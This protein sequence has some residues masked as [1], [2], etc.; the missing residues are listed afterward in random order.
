[1]NELQTFTHKQFGNVRALNIKGEPWFVAVDVCKALGVG[2]PTQALTRLDDDE[3]ANTLISNEGIRGNPNMAIVNEPGLY[4]LVLS[5]RK[6]QAKAFKR[7]LTHDVI[8]S[9]RKYGAYMTPETLEAAILN[10]D[11]MIKLC[12]Q[13]KEEQK[14]RKALELANQTLTTENRVLRPKADY[15]D[16]VISR[17]KVSGIRETAKA[18]K[19]KQNDFVKLLIDNHYLYRDGSGRLQPYSR[20]VPSLFELKECVSAS[21]FWSGTQT[22]ITPKGRQTF[23]KL[24]Q[25]ALTA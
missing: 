22:M 7:W 6:P 19:M 8:P 4:T 9:I 12:M 17:G 15:F 1:M 11:T 24:C 2:N 20:Y 23:H 5:S 14:K 21:Q 13:L 18:L 25:K 16:D 3:K 10:P